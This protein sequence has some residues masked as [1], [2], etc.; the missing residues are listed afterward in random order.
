MNKE[1]KKLF[2][3]AGIFALL[4]VA[5]FVLQASV[6]NAQKRLALMKSVH[7]EMSGNKAELISMSEET[8][9][10]KARAAEGKNRNFVS[11]MEKTVSEFGLSKGLKK[12]NFVTHRQDGQFSADDYE[13]KIEGVD[14]NTAVNFIFRISNAG[15][16][17]KVKKC[18]LAVSFENPSL[19]NISLL[20]SHIT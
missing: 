10:L 15:V 18:S 2:I 14:I 8:K 12:I 13:L 19:L 11:E 9:A 6:N 3:F 7:S 5:V 17:V 1:K 20:V 16:L 4:V